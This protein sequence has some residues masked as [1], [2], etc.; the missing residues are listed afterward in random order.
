MSEPPAQLHT[1]TSPLPNKNHSNRDARLANLLRNSYCQNDR[2]T[3]ELSD[4]K[5]RLE[6]SEA[7]RRVTLEYYE[8]LNKC[9]AAIESPT[10]H[11]RAV[12]H[13]I[14]RDGLTG[15]HIPNINWRLDDCRLYSAN[16]RIAAALPPLPP[17]ISVGRPRSGSFDTLPISLHHPL[18]NDFAI[19]NMTTSPLFF[20]SSIRATSKDMEDLLLDAAGNERSHLN[21]DDQPSQSPPAVL[22]AHQSRGILVGPLDQPGQLRTDQPCIFAPPVT[23]APKERATQGPAQISVPHNAIIPTFAPVPCT[24]SFHANNAL[25]QR[26]CRQCDPPRRY[27]DKKCVERWGPRPEEPGTVGRMRPLQ[28]KNEANGTAETTDANVGDSSS[29]I[30]ARLHCTYIIPVGVMAGTQ[31]QTQ[32]FA[33][34][35]SLAPSV[36]L[37]EKIVL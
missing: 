8:E 12:L 10:A 23:G 17:F 1:M 24:T 2:L 25:G 22:A 26:I 36:S 35:A 27:K 18:P 9:L 32:A 5:K 4:T 11:A 6:K 13:R 37:Q 3:E 30:A 29:A 16:P 21:A 14:L 31:T 7:S 33:G 20:R 28:K 19:G 15:G 34:S